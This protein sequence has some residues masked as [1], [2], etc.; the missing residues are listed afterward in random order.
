MFGNV[1]SDDECCHENWPITVGANAKGGVDREEF[2][3]GMQT[4]ILKL[5]PG[6]ANEPGQRV[7]I[8]VD[9]GP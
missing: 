2:E 1:N 9:S 3:K 7:M 5:H 6:A 4:N 8:K